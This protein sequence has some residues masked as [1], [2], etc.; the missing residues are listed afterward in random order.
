MSQTRLG[1]IFVFACAAVIAGANPASAE[2]L[3]LAWDANIE[4][5]VI[6]YV[7]YMGPSP[8]AYNQRVDVGPATQFAV[9]ASP[10][11][12][13]CFAVS[14]YIAG[15]EEGPQSAEICATAT[16]RSSNTAPTLANPGDQSSPVGQ[17]L[18]MSLSA[19]DPEGAPLTYN[20]SGLPAGLTLAGTGVISGTPTQTG[21]STVSATVSDGEYSATVSFGWTVTG[22]APGAAT[23]LRPAGAIT[24]TAPIF[25]WTPVATATRYRLWADDAGPNQQLQRDLTPAEAGC[26]TITA[27]AVCRSGLGLT[28]MAGAASWSVR[29]TN[30]FGDGP[31]SGAMDFTVPGTQGSQ[32]PTVTIVTPT[33]AATYSTG[34]ATMALAGTATDDLAVTQVS[35]AT[36]KGASGIAAGTSSWSVPSISLQPGANVITI[37]ARDASNNTATDVLTVTFVDDT[38]APIVAIALPTT[39]ATYSTATSSLALSGTAADN[40]AVSDVRWSNSQGGSGLATGTAGAIG[41]SWSTGTIALKAGANAITI[42]ARDAAGNTGTDVLTVTV[43]DGQAPT[44]A[45][46]LPTAAATY[47]TSSLTLALGGTTSDDVGVTEVGWSNSQGGSGVA[48][49]TS[50]WSAGAITLKPGANVITV[51]ARDAAGNLAA[52]VLTVTVSDGQRADDLTF[53]QPTA[54]GH[55]L[56]EPATSV[57]PGSGSR[58]VLTVTVD[59]QARGRTARAARASPAARPPGPRARSP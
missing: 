27:A 18:T 49:G 30:A 25:E 26:A 9:E 38:Q 29:A 33:T 50:T 59:G 53:A 57:A 43:S 19:I 20:V 52:D 58:T 35:W 15:S 44:V 37:T 2:T 23:L 28:L 56:D 45:I 54:A 47:S 34:T 11:S 24:T 22:S 32:G 7:V 6:G 16:A 5:Q 48:S 41:F 40:V 55:L 46:S 8:G 4:P 42:T 1:P 14:A 10:G 39:A 51:T 31:W 36:D 13:Y 12:A 17:S 21:T 3:T